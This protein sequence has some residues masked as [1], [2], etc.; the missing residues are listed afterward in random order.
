[1]TKATEPLDI[2]ELLTQIE[3]TELGGL[4]LGVLKSTNKMPKIVQVDQSLPN[5]ADA[6]Y[7][8]GDNVITLDRGSVRTK[9]S[10]I[11]T[12]THELTHAATTEMTK[13]I[14]GVGSE[15][16]DRYT[17]DN[18]RKL[19]SDK[20][21]EPT[22]NLISK[23]TKNDEYRANP[24]EA[25]A[26]GV[27]NTV[28]GASNPRYYSVPHADA[29]QAQEFAITVDLYTRMKNKQQADIKAKENSP[30]II[31]KILSYLK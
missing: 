29:T 31:D 28:T 17:N 3:G 4:V 30:G 27:G 21:F 13:S 9:D 10:A 22:R 15:K 1:M 7:N 19:G 20:T 23:A 2:E 24:R 16:V 12:L 6:N 5:Y 14:Y 11:S 8:S 26:F 25:I 18:L